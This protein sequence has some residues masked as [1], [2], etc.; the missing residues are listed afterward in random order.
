M[1]SPNIFDFTA[2]S[3]ITNW[4]VVDDVVMGGKSSGHFKLDANG[5]GVFY[6]DV[7]LANNGGFSSVQYS[8]ETLYTKSFTN[9]VLNLKGDGKAYQFRVKANAEDKHSYIAQFET[10][11]AWQKISIPLKTM[12]PTFRGRKLEQP[13]FFEGQIEQ[14]AFL[15]GNK[16]AEAFQL[17]IDSITLE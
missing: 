8:L 3:N 9:V 14:I 15:V 10:T 5:H 17:L 16:R 13:N 2:T 6:G 11:G 1:G 7:S 12:Y 4:R